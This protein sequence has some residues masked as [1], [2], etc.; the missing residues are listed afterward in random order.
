[1]C[2]GN[3]WTTQTR[4]AMS[5]FTTPNDIDVFYLMVPRPVESD[6]FLAS[7]GSPMMP[8]T[9]PLWLSIF[10]FTIVIAL[11]KAKLA[12]DDD[13]LTENLHTYGPG[14]V[15]KH[16]V[17][18]TLMELLGGGVD[19]TVEKTT[20]GPRL[21]NLGFA[22]FVVV[23]ISAYTA[24]LAAMLATKHLEGGSI[25]SMQD[26][27]D[28]KCTLCMHPVMEETMQNMYGT[29]G[30]DLR[31]IGTGSSKQLVEA[32]PTSQ[33]DATMLDY[34]SYRVYLD[35]YV[36]LCDF[37][38]AGSGLAWT[39]VA[40]PIRD[41]LVNSMSFWLRTIVTDGTFTSIMEEYVP[42]PT[43]VCDPFLATSSSGDSGALG[44]NNLAGPFLL[45]GL[46]VAIALALDIRHIG[47][48]AFVHG[49]FLRFGPAEKAKKRSLSFSAVDST[50]PNAESAT[51]A[52][53]PDGDVLMQQIADL[54]SK[55]DTMGTKVDAVDSKVDTMDSRFDTMDSKVDK[56]DSK[57]DTIM[58]SKVETIN[59]H[60]TPPQQPANTGMFCANPYVEAYHI[61]A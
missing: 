36:D 28:L 41:D 3:F 16:E 18:H 55:V 11:V 34:Y 38:F 12:T 52:P 25:Q 22:C 24:N 8:F 57:V 56:M 44:L 53:V 17:Y 6:N 47:C 51:A 14:G 60:L 40:Q 2:I 10:V 45:C 46:L 39:P 43:S 33:C 9:T 19:A 48:R 31:V 58:D 32:A 42:N 5:S 1:M 20:V 13:H 37:Y 54:V 4:M 61:V 26:C 29:S 49:C 7:L 23:V 27:V 59:S 30:I 21:V 15:L 50:I 35:Q